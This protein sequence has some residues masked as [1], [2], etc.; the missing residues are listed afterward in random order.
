MFVLASEF[1]THFLE[2]RK[3]T[4]RIHRLI[5][6]VT[7]T[8]PIPAAVMGADML[9]LNVG[10]V[11]AFYG[12]LLQMLLL[13]LAYLGAGIVIFR[14]G[15]T[16]AVFFLLAWFCL[17]VGVWIYL[18]STLGNEVIPVSIWTENAVAQ[19]V[20]TTAGSLL[21]ELASIDSASGLKRRINY[22]AKPQ[23]LLIDEV[24][25]LS[26]GTRHADLL[27]ELLNQRYEKQSTIVT[28]NRPF[29]EWTEVFPNAACVTSL[30]DRLMHHAEIVGIEGDSFRL[31]EAM[32][33]QEKRGKK[34]TKAKGD[35]HE[36]PE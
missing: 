1:V 18:I 31:R 8:L 28:T 32:E 6:W 10:I 12:L 26:Y 13:T 33:R 29:S 11:S 3:R 5:V 35:T 34:S 16:P 27:F 17:A 30:V 15:F 7:S 9:G 14:Q 25:Y 19:V 4:P 24:G 23:L 21:N 20:C 36:K 2:T 22:Y